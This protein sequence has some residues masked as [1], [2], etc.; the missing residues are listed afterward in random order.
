MKLGY[1][2]SIIDQKRINAEAG[3]AFAYVNNGKRL[4]S[5]L[6][7][8]DVQESKIGKS[9]EEIERSKQVKRAVYNKQKADLALMLAEANEKARKEKE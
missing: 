2:Y 3:W 8:L 9:Q 7:A 1:E 5:Y 6:S 4:T